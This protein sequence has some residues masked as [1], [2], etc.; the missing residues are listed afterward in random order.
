MRKFTKEEKEEFIKKHYYTCEKCGYNNEK[1]R[2]MQFGTCLKCG[3][4]LDDKV[5]FMIEMMKRMKENKRK[6]G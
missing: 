1:S 5:Y 4:K 6:K 2:F 3:N